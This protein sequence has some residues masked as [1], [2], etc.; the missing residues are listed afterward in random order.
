MSDQ[1]HGVLREVLAE[2]R[3]KPVPAPS[4]LFTTDFRARPDQ[5]DWRLLPVPQVA[6]D[7]PAAGYLATLAT[8]D[9]EELTALLRAAPQRTVEVELRLANAL[10]EQRDY[11]Q[12][13]ELL[14]AIAADDPWEWRVSWYQGVAALAQEWPAAA[15]ASFTAVYEAVPGE[16]APKLAIAVAR[17][18]CGEHA[19]AAAWYEIVSRT[20]P[21]YTT[22][23]FGLEAQT[24]KIEC[25]LAHDDGHE[26]EIAELQT[27][28]ASMQALSLDGEQRAQLTVDVLLAALQLLENERVAENPDLRLAG[29][30]LTEQ[31]VRL[32]LESTYRSLARV[33]PST[34]ERIRL[35]DWANRVRPRTWT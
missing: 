4:T 7:D 13:E 33:A 24:A 11:A 3:G 17:E 19:D 18:C 10:I 16:L 12:A 21:S 32:G 2:Q 9:P 22:A 6:S 27:A 23:T 35:V 14:S 26:H 30:A 15:R 31:D 28:A 5:A 20:D 8:S 29:C 1:L 34:S 25:L